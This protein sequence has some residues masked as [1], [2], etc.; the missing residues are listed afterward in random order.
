MGQSFAGADVESSENALA[1]CVD[2]DGAG[3]VEGQN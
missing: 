1:C 2:V 3:V